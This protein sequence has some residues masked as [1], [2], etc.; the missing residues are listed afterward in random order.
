MGGVMALFPNQKRQKYNARKVQL[1]GQTFDSQKEANYYLD[2]KARVA[3]GELRYILRQVP[4]HL[5]GGVKYLCDF[6]EHYPDGSVRYVDVKGQRTDL[7]IV[8]KKM[9]ESL[10]P[11]E[12]VEV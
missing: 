11:V 1:D 9:V 8:K 7:Y 5:P 10:Y 3:E 6:Q 2:C 4:F 12:I